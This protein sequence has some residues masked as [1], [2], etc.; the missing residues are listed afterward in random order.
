MEIEQTEAIVIGAGVIGLACARALAGRGIETLI[1]EQHE[2]FGQE[3]SSRNSEVIHAGLYYPSD[4]LKARFCVE[5]NR[6]LYDYCS[7]RG[8]S[9]KRCGKLIVATQEA[10]IAHLRKL[11]EQ[12][13]QNGVSDTCML[14]RH[15]AQALEPTLHCVAALHSPSTGIVDSHAL[16]LSLLGD[17][18]AHGAVFSPHS[19]VR[20]I[21]A[22]KGAIRLEVASGGAE[23]LLETGLVINA[24]GLSAVALAHTIEGYAPSLV[25]SAYLAKGN[26]Y[27]LVGRS[28]FSHLVYPVPEEGGLG[29]HLTLDLGGQAR[30]GP[31]VEWIDRVDYSVDPRRADRF[32]A[33][34]RKYWPEL[35]DDSLM[36]AY[37]GIRPK[38]SGPGSPAADFLIQGPESHGIV[39]LVNLFGI[40][41]PG[42]TACLAIA[43]H[44][45]RLLFPCR[46]N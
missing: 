12:A 37:S 15:E 22:R 29:V 3:T 31:D 34:V 7:T 25:P 8:I 26:Y 30:F 6:K 42:L 18:E 28:P 24:A 44:T 27:A 4:T 32:Y 17:A 36:P 2:D 41:S 14:D 35:P 39:G 45:D 21:E 11:Q 1:L 23:M 13:I 40:E 20:A 16:M 19:T 43:E 33:E 38:I 10:Q 9:Y 5:G 46:E